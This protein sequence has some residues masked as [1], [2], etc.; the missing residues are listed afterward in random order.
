MLKRTTKQAFWVGV[1]GI[2][3]LTAM[4][5]TMRQSGW[6]FPE[7]PIEPRTNS[8][9]AEIVG[10][11]DTAMQYARALQQGNCDQAIAMT[12]WMQER[13]KQVQL[14]EQERVADIREELC[15]SLTDRRLE[16]NRFSEEGMEDHYVFAPG[17]TLTLVN[18]E[19]G[20]QDLERPAASRAWIRVE[21]PRKDRAPLS[22]EGEPIRSLVAKV[23]TTADAFVLKAA[24][25]GNTEIDSEL[26]N[27]GW[28][29]SGGDG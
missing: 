3:L 8:A 24:V 6:P 23:S 22:S 25:I 4:V 20:P 27:T 12:L 1:I 19:P 2:A 10:T 13:I 28:N 11:G 17:T 26:I 29:T 7:S 15:A 18:V 21:Y 14:Q 9:S 16:G 5:I